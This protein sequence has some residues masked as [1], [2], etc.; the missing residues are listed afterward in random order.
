MGSEMCIRDRT[1]PVTPLMVCVC[2]SPKSTS[3]DRI[4]FEVVAVDGVNVIDT[5]CPSTGLLGELVIVSVGAVTTLMVT[6]PVLS[7]TVAV[8]LETRFVVS[9]VCATP[10]ESVVAEL[11]ASDP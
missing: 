4:G 9:V 7:A 6:V 8:T 2:P 3:T 1:G 5:G 10:F 11:A